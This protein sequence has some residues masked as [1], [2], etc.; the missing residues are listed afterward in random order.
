MCGGKKSKIFSV[1][2]NCFP[3][4]ARRWSMA[5]AARHGAVLETSSDGERDERDTFFVTNSCSCSSGVVRWR[6]RER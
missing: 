3:I 1:K 6:H 4:A 5:G 2:Y